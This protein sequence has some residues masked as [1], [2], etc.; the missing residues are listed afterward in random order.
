[1]D[2]SV[3]GIVFQVMVI[4]RIAG[5][6]QGIQIDNMPVRAVLMNMFDKIGPDESGSAGD[7]YLFHKTVSL[8]ADPGLEQVQ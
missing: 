7:Q 3:P 5:I 6:G 1:V 4:D 8:F 2:K